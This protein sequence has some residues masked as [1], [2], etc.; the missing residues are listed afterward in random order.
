MTP[1]P[2]G[3]AVILCGGAGLRLW[4]ASNA[5]RPKPFL[6][7]QDGRSLLQ[8]AALRARRANPEATVL[9]VTH[10]RLLEAARRELAGLVP[11]DRL[12]FI[13]EPFGRDTAPAIAFAAHWVAGRQGEDQALLVLPADHLI[14]DEDAFAEA[15][16]AAADLARKGW[17]AILGVPPASPSPSFGYLQ[18]GERMDSGWRV[19]RF[20][21]KPSAEA[22][23]DLLAEGGWWWNS[24]IFCFTAR[25]VLAELAAAAPGP[26]E[27]IRACWTATDPGDPARLDEATLAAVPSLGFDRAV[28]ERSPRVAG[29]VAGFDWRDVGGWDSL[30][31][32]LPADADGNRLQGAAVAHRSSGCHVRSETRLVAAVGVRDLTIVDTPEALLV[33]GNDAVGELRAFVEGLPTKADTGGEGRR[34]EWGCSRLLARAGGLEVHQFVIH[35]GAAPRLGP[36]DDGS[37]HWVVGSGRLAVSLDGRLVELGEN[38]SARLPAGREHRLR[39]PGD[40]DCIAVRV[41]LATPAP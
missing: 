20:V 34:E 22:A 6:R 1:Q 30:A 26:S 41:R 40:V 10:R 18:F 35:P 14:E 21:E 28:L 33:A 17:L 31:A 19:R 11:P 32:A 4:P 37:G 7:M 3:V 13:L 36:G 16:A 15:A 39:N 27:A 24:G 8:M 25:T 2:P 23:A 29:L 9:V 12:H 38:E 5:A